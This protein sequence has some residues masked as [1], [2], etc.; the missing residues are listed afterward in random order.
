MAVKMEWDVNN[1]R[2]LANK[3]TNKK[4]KHLYPFLFDDAKL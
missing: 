4:N 2:N 3:P 1:L